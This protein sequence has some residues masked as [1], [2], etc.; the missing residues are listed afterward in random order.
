MTV[1]P[2]SSWAQVLTVVVGFLAML[3][4]TVGVYASLRSTDAVHSEQ[5]RRVQTDVQHL[6]RKLDS[7]LTLT[8]K[9][10]VKVGVTDAGYDPPK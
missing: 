8:W 2:K 10:A 5:I 9:V 4:A 3:G 6:E 1:R 7:L